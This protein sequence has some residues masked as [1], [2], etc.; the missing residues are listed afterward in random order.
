[1][2]DYDCEDGEDEDQN[3]G[4]T[5]WHGEIYLLSGE[6]SSDSIGTELTPDHEGFMAASEYICNWLGR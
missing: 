5:T 2:A 6:V 1:M 4:N 3:S